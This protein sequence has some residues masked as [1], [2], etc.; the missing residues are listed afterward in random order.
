MLRARKITKPLNI[1]KSVQS[2]SASNASNA[3][4]TLRASKTVV[5]ESEATTTT[6]SVAELNF[7]ASR[8]GTFYQEAPVL[9]NQFT[10]DVFLQ[11]YLRRVLSQ[12]VKISHSRVL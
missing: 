1:L 10:R 11:D 8:R 7:A 12:E 9:G 2:N 3:S 5:S 6:R 4:R